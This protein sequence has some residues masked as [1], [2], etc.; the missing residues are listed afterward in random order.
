MLVFAI[1]GITLVSIHA[2]SGDDVRD[3]LCLIH[4]RDIGETISS[5]QRSDGSNKFIPI[6]LVQVDGEINVRQATRYGPDSDYGVSSEGDARGWLSMFPTG[7]QEPCYQFTSG[8]VKMDPDLEMDEL[9]P[10][11]IALIVLSVLWCGLTAALLYR[12]YRKREADGKIAP[13][14]DAEEMA[15]GYPLPLQQ[16]AYGGPAAWPPYG[17]LGPGSAAYAA[18]W[19]PP[20]QPQLALP[21]PGYGSPM[22]PG[23][24]MHLGMGMTSPFSMPAHMG[25]MAPHMMGGM[26]MMGMP[27]AGMPMGGML[28]PG[29]PRP[30]GGMGMPPP[31]MGV[32]MPPGYGAPQPPWLQQA[33][34]SPMLALT[35]Y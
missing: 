31:P 21:A 24:M 19:Q 26:P 4:G 35:G 8:D 12:L 6:V 34:M 13:E 10:V 9:L 16:A 22:M 23:P 28:V 17:G 1:I 32:G 20:A 25:G 30:M 11:G 5:K 7:D 14:K 33:P 15:P 18:P 3:T 29:M 2:S 27:M